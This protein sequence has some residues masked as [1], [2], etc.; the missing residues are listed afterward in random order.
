MVIMPHDLKYVN[1]QSNQ[2]NLTLKTEYFFQR[3]NRRFSHTIKPFTNPALNGKL[4][5]Y[6]RREETDNE[7]HRQP[8]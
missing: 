6:I 7:N 1:L 8:E 3:C 4:V 5:P 2:A